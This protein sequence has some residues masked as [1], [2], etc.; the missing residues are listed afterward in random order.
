VG[1]KKCFLGLRQTALLSAEGKNE[2]IMV[3]LRIT[4]IIR[5]HH[6]MASLDRRPSTFYCCELCSVTINELFGSSF[7]RLT[8]YDGFVSPLGH[9]R[10]PMSRLQ[11][12]LPQALF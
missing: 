8:F 3:S 11:G 9:R 4:G 2:G 6:Q 5:W 1:V 10:H 12:L 7:Q